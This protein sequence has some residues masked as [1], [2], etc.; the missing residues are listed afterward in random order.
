MNDKRP[1]ADGDGLQMS[2]AC[3][4]TSFGGY[5]D[6]LGPIGLTVLLPGSF[7]ALVKGQH[8]STLEPN[9]LFETYQFTCVIIAC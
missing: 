6:S 1:E 5:I 8:L 7:N 9:S 2:V 3:S 4:C